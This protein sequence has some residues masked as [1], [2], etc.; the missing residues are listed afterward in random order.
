MAKDVVRARD[1]LAKLRGTLTTSEERRQAE[2]E[3]EAAKAALAA[4]QDKL[5][6]LKTGKAPAAVTPA[7]PEVTPREIRAWASEEGIQC[8]PNGK[9][10]A[11]VR[12]RYDAAHASELSTGWDVGCGRA[13]RPRPWRCGSRSSR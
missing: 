2:A 3:I 6:R 5:R 11:S 12:E 8:A 9:I 1:A 4:A 10:P 7:S 13:V